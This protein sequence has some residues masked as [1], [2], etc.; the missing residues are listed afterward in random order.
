LQ[1]IGTTNWSYFN[2]QVD[3][4]SNNEKDNI[5]FNIKRVKFKP[6]YMTTWREARSV[7][8]T[9][10]FLKIKY[11]YKLTNYLSKYKKF[12]NFKT[13]LFMEMRLINILIKSRLFN[14]FNISNFFLKNNLIFLNGYLCNNANM[15]IFCGDFIQLIINLKYY[16]LY[17]WFLNLSLK[18]KNKLKNVLKK[19]HTNFNQLDDKK[20]SYS[21]PKWVLHSKNI[22]DDVPSFLEIDYFTL[23]L[24]V[25]YEPF[26]WNDLNS[27]NLIE[28][29]F[30]IINLYNWKYIT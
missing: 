2:T 21:L 22:I 3:Y 15:Q 13:F 6:G 23:S 25:L 14:N 24:F 8:K 27:Y 17:R 26:N 10:L 12:I 18:K 16:I 30:S 5:N 19:K 4:S 1:N 20:K 7:L 29:K 9:S 28:Q 11:Q